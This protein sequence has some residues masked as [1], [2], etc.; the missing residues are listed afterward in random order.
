[1]ITERIE[2]RQTEFLLKIKTKLV[3]KHTENHASEQRLLKKI[4]HENALP[5][6]E[7]QIA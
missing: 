2:K 7:S 4:I 3:R 5:F 6:C 1:M